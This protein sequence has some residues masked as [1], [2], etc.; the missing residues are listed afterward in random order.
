ML[1]QFKYRRSA[2]ALQLQSLAGKLNWA[3]QAVPGG[4]YFL[5]R[6]LDCMNSIK[7]L[8]HK[9]KLSQEFKLDIGWW[10]D[11]ALPNCGTTYYCCDREKVHALS[12]SSATAAGVYCQ[13][14]WHYTNF[15]QDWP[16]IASE[17]IN[18]KE[19]TGAITAIYRWVPLWYK[20]KVVIHMDKYYSQFHHE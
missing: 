9:V 8:R 19:I 16:E 13:G 2:T 17:H 12:D 14:D 5:R 1:I 18:Y 11:Y 15:K 10:L 20:K 3:T 6:I 7:N 4:R